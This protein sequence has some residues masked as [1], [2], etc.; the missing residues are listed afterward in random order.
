[1]MTASPV[2]AAPAAGP[3]SSLSVAKAVRAS[4]PSGKKSELAAPG[5]IIGLVLAAAVIAG[6]VLIAIDDDSDSN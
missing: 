5:A 2:L 4:T 6:G 3:A 1:M